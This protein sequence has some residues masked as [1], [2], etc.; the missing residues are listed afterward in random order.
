MKIR[1]KFSLFTGLVV[2]GT[3]T[4]VAALAFL[5]QKD[6]IEKNMAEARMNQT[7]GFAAVCKQALIVDNELSMIN[8]VKLLKDLPGITYV[9]FADKQSKIRVHSDIRV[10]YKSLKQWNK[11]KPDGVSETQH[12]VVVGS[13]KGGTA[14]IGFSE[15]FQKEILQKALKKTLTQVTMAASAVALVVL[16][17]ALIF[18]YILT[19]PL[20]ALSDGSEEISKGNFQTEVKVTSHDEL[21]E[22]ADRFNSMAKNLAILDELKDEFISS[23]SH[24]LRS[25]MS[26]INMYT[27]FML[28]DD[29]DK[30]KILPQH[31]EFLRII[32]FN[33]ARLGVFVTNILDAAKIK[34]GRAEYHPQPMDAGATAQTIH[35][36][37]DMM[38]R[39]KQ[40]SLQ[41]NVPQA[42]PKIMA[43]PERFDHVITNL[44]SNALKY[45]PANGTITLGAVQRGNRVDVYVQDTGKGIKPDDLAHLFERFRQVEVADQRAK[46]IQ[47][48]G[49]GLYIVKQTVE[50]MGGEIFAASEVGKGT[51]FTV[52]LP[53]APQLTP[54]N[55]RY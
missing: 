22:L 47:G 10:L 36:L 30:D 2:L 44:I 17:A 5:L 40:I 51:C 7:S 9:Y 12:P 41:I 18:A 52:S 45:T 6:L 53:I 54:Q 16:L 31:Q 48:T 1:T 14:V 42:L 3:T 21:G 32:Q 19:R 34:A 35:K 49:L 55:T 38:A 4:A 33:A 15:E 13:S 20:K 25:P 46:R 29:P 8:Y 50:G 24:D 43:D 26:A 39:K 11:I 37:F 28:N 23:V 27:N